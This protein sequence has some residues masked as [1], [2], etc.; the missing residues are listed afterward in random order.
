MNSAWKI[1]SRVSCVGHAGPRDARAPRAVLPSGRGLRNRA[2]TCFDFA[3]RCI[4]RVARNKGGLLILKFILIG[5]KAWLA[6]IRHC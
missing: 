5:R 3:I 1:C 2:A 4:Y 6:L